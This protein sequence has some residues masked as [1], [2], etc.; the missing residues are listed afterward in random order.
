MRTRA[1]AEVDE[2]VEAMKKRGLVVNQPDE[3]QRKAWD[4]LA[5]GLY[6][7]IRGTLV[8]ADAFD[9]VFLHL[10]AFRSNKGG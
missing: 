5:E 7:R 8:P 4:D 9:E 2:A 10:K 3:S 1:R 6:P